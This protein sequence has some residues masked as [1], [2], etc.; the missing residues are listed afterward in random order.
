[1]KES[2]RVRYFTAILIPVGTVILV[3]SVLA[4]LTAM[5]DGWGPRAQ[6][7]LTE[8]VVWWAGHWWMVALVLASLCVI[9]AV[10]HEAQAPAKKKK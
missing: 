1:M 2:A 4:I 6:G 5:A 10:V 9:G 7:T 8:V 3:F